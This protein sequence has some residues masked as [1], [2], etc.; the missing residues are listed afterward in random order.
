LKLALDAI[1]ADRPEDAIARLT[2][3][4]DRDHSNPL[5]L[6]LLGVALTRA[7]DLE[8]AIDSLDRAHYLE[9]DNPQILVDYG[10]ALLAAGRDGQARSRF[11]AA[12]RL[13]PGHAAALRSL[14]DLYQRL[15]SRPSPARP[16]GSPRP[17]APPPVQ[18]QRPE[19]SHSAPPPSPPTVPPPTATPPARIREA[20]PDMGGPS[21]S[22]GMPDSRLPRP[23]A[24]IDFSTS[25]ADEGD[26]SRWDPEPLPSFTNLARATLQL[27]G[28]QPLVW[29]LILAVPNALVAYFVPDAPEM[30]WAAAIIWTAAL[31]LGA[32]PAMLAMSN[33]WIF[34]RIQAGSQRPTGS[35]LVHGIAMSL[36]YALLLV[37]PFAIALALRSPFPPAVIVLG[38]LL[39]TAP[40]HALLGP[41]VLLSATD[42]PPGWPALRK[43][44]LLAG[45]RSWIHLALMVAVGVVVG[46]SLATIAWAFAVTLRGQ[47]DAVSRVMEV[48]GLS[49]G[50]S[51]WV[52]LLTISG[53]DAISAAEAENQPAE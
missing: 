12:L 11:E 13:E 40:F 50:E 37:G 25:G 9:P 29:L 20:R 26:A 42:G 27:W 10:N 39:L 30:R 49:L 17:S 41:A 14:G 3:Q 48:A 45:K 34:G 47:G 19:L 7:G 36:I 51:L 4:L 23:R 24:P 18:R 52:A 21:S 5:L 6:A 46:G 28:Q 53:L 38:V 43:S 15:A 44:W 2:A 1:E 35:S 32:G 33:Q 22:L 16:D 8:A 31:G